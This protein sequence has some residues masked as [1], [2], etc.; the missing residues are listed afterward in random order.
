MLLQSPLVFNGRMFTLLC[1]LLL[2]VR[3][4]KKGCKQINVTAFSLVAPP[5]GLE[6]WTL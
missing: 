3:Q 2:R 6:P 5:Q 4:I 1:E